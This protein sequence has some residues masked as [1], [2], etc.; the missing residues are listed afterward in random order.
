MNLFRTEAVMTHT[1]LGNVIILATV[2]NKF[3]NRRNESYAYACHVETQRKRRADNRTFVS[4]VG[5]V[6]FVW[7][8]LLG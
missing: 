2:L 4:S 6:T 3:H 5:M 7:Y 8:F 1:G